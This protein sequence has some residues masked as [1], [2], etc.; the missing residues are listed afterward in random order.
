[1]EQNK[2]EVSKKVKKPKKETTTKVVNS[3]TK[4][5]DLIFGKKKK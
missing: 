5:S 2:K 4:N 1:M 3:K